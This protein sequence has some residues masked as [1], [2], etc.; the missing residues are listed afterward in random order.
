MGIFL[1]TNVIME[2]L[3]NRQHADEVEKLISYA[4]DHNH[5]LFV[6]S[7][8]LYTLSY[9]VEKHLK[10]IGLNGERKIDALRKQLL[11]ILDIVEIANTDA[12]GFV[13]G[14][15]NQDFNDI[16]DISISSGNRQPLRHCRY[17]EYK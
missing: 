17:I 6:S 7:G 8:S 12:K 11:G 15:N 13:L 4:I 16:E 1:D 9:I 3:C 5:L 14:V 2:L 10:N